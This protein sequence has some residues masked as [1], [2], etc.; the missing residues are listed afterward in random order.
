M[1][2]GSVSGCGGGPSMAGMMGAGGPGQMSGP[3]KAAGGGGSPQ[4][5][6][7]MFGKDSF[8]AAGG[9]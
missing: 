5:L 1:G 9:G 8:Q 4:G 3:E 7:D 2:C 6:C